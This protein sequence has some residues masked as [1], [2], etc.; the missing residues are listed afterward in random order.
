MARNNPSTLTWLVLGGGAAAYFLWAKPKMD[1]QAAARAAVWEG[2][3]QKPPPRDWLSDILGLTV[4]V[5]E[6]RQQEAARRAAFERAV[7]DAFRGGGAGA[8]ASSDT[9]NVT[10]LI[11]SLRGVGNYCRA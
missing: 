9:S 5:V 7:K 11:D 6:A 8:A 1:A 4:S 10:P 3:G 2:A